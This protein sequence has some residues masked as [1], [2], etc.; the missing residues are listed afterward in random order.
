MTS[1]DQASILVSQYLDWQTKNLN[2]NVKEDK[3]SRFIIETPFARADGHAF[4]IE[5]CFL[6]GG[7][8][9]FTDIGGTLDEL[10]MQGITL[11]PPIIDQI[12]R[13]ARRFRVKLS[14][15]D[16]VLRNDGDGGARQF[17]DLVSAILAISA[18]IDRRSEAVQGEGDSSGSAEVP[19]FG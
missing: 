7:M 4:D 14:V 5:V 3:E 2:I 12:E 10:W 8:V 19:S 6:D 11:N 18:L 9:R 1:Y 16:H 15:E 13:I 17:Q